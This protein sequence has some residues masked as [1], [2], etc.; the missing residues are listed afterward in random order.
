MFKAG[1]QSY[2]IIAIAGMKWSILQQHKEVEMLCEEGMISIKERS[3]LLVPHSIKQIALAKTHSNI[4]T[5]DKHCT[6][7]GMVNHNAETCK[8][9][10]EKTMVATTKATQPSKKP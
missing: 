9:K 3:A 7:C 5:L 10:K 6:N 2:L 4:G 1:S 8:K